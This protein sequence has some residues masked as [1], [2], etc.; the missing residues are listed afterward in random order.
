MMGTLRQPRMQPALRVCAVVSMFFW[1][2]GVS[3][4]SLE[5]LLGPVAANHHA[6]HAGDDH[7][8]H[9]DGQPAEGSGASHDSDKNGPI[10][11]PCCKSLTT[12]AQ[13]P[14]SSHIAKPQ[15][16]HFFSFDF[17]MPAQALTLVQPDVAPTHHART[18]KRVL[19]PVL[20][21]GP[22]IRSRA[23]PVAV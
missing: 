5:S 2:S 14:G 1:L 12:V 23:P 19:T 18:C 15:W 10:D 6:S 17:D 16:V 4:C 3:Y 13:I 7:H 9:E 22:A 11:D 8:H 21:L 20:C